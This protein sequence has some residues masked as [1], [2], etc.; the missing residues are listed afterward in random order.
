[1]GRDLAG[2]SLFIGSFSP[3]VSTPAELRRP[4]LGY[5]LH[6]EHWGQGLTSAISVQLVDGAFTVL[7]VETVRAETMAVNRASRR[8]MTRAGLSHIRTFHVHFDDPLPGTDAGEVEYAIHRHDWLTQRI[9]PTP[10]RDT[11]VLSGE[12]LDGIRGRRQRQRYKSS[13][14]GG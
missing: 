8:V 13:L 5:W 12:G 1:M 7:R 3:Y 14:T 4:E 10:D 6:P 9:P 2:S 11:P